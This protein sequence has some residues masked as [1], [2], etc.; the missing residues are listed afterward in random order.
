[1]SQRLTVHKD[2]QHPVDALWWK[3]VFSMQKELSQSFKQM[4]DQFMKPFGGAPD[5]LWDAEDTMMD[6]LQENTHRMFSELFNNRQ[7]TT[8]LLTGDMTE[9]YVNIIENGKA[10]KIRA[11][12]P[13]L[14]A[15]DLDVSISESAITITGTRCLDTEDKGDTYLR[16][17]CHCGAF[18]RTIAMPP[19]AN[20]DKAK[21]SFDKN[22]LMVEIPKSHSASYASPSRS[23][24]IEPSAMTNHQA[25]AKPKAKTARKSAKK[26]SADESVAQPILVSRKNTPSGRSA[27][28]AK[29]A[30]QHTRTRAA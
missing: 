10:F 25:E 23:L 1:M 7:L 24:D 14:S 12:V 16:H 26:V 15:K 29:K 22:V 28:S 30:A 13:G 9:P 19:E 20:M 4:A 2:K 27:R 18:S 6:M 17:E 3:P 11:D 5:A 21:A 8:P